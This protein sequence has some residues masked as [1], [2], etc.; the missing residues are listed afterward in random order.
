MNK[1]NEGLSTA[2]HLGTRYRCE[3]HLLGRKSLQYAM[4]W[5]RRRGYQS[6]RPYLQKK[7]EATVTQLGRLN[8]L[9]EVAKR[10]NKTVTNVKKENDMRRKLFSIMRCLH[11]LRWCSSPVSMTSCAGDDIN[12]TAERMASPY[13]RF[14]HKLMCREQTVSRGLKWPA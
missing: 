4:S 8:R 1:R 5:W 12:L 13:V 2:Q 14:Q 11:F 9:R 7:M 10:Q 3:S 6:N